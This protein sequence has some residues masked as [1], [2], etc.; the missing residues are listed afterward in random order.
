MPSKWDLFLHH[1][2]T[3]SQIITVHTQCTNCRM[4]QIR[5]SRIGPRQIHHI[6]PSSACT[7]KLVMLPS[8]EN[9]WNPFVCCWQV[10]LANGPQLR[11]ATSKPYCSLQKIRA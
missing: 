4:S 2:Y 7:T 10:E 8:T 11:V 3:I 9:R 6:M 1:G 5:S